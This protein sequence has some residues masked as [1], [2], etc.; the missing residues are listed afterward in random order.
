VSRVPVTGK[1]ATESPVPAVSS[2]IAVTVFS[3]IPR[4]GS[5]RAQ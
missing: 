3:I 5:V 2:I 4:G 1:L